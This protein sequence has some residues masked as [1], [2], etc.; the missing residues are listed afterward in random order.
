MFSFIGIF[1]IFIIAVGFGVKRNLEYD[2]NGYNA[3]ITRGKYDV[4]VKRIHGHDYIIGTVGKL[5]AVTSN[6]I[7]IVHA[8]SCTN[9]KCR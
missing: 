3:P 2:E 6:G 9:S 5:T 4:E 8:E 1:A 7:A